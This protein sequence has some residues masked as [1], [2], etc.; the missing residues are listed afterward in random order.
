M[1]SGQSN[2]FASLE[3]REFR[4]L[5]VGALNA[6]V[7]FFMSNVVQAVVAFQL[8]G[9]NRAVGFVVFSRGL[10]MM[11]FGPV[12]G[13]A[14]D[15]I[16]KR[17]I[18]LVCQ[19]VT[20]AV[21]V[22]LALLTSTGALAIEHLVVAG[23]IIGTT[24]AFLGPTRQAYV[25]EL[26]PAERRGN[27]IAL[28]QVALNASRVGGPALAG[29]VLALDAVGATG[30]FAFMGLLYAIAMLYH[31]RLTRG[32]PGPDFAAGGVLADVMLGLRYVSGQRRLRSYLLYFVLIVMFGFPYVTVFPGFVEHQLGLGGELVSLLFGMSAAGG[33]GASLLL[34]SFADRP[35][36]PRLYLLSSFA[37]GLSLVVLSFCHTLW[38]AGAAVVLV[39]V[40]SGAITT[41]NSTI[42]LR[43]SDPAYVG[44][45]MSLAMLAFAGFGLAG[46][47]IGYLADHLGE[48]V[49]LR[50]MGAI[51][52][53]L[54]L[55]HTGVLRERAAGVERV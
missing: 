42:L 49:T 53:V 10:A 24:F 54:A 27:A 23:F 45:V 35:E 40:T 38:A 43:E 8:T 20:T 13:A 51:V 3:N 26:V 19:G 2:L 34:A 30:A 22:A 29:V 28:N 21:F 1:P 36:T 31:A 52:V 55:F 50:M 39:G 14:A 41:L 9:Q 37:F 6:F 12:G 18:L 48:G 7:A 47:P 4:L 46:L 17:R 25:V 5:W 16:D 33:L 11:L 32:A 44:R 15:R